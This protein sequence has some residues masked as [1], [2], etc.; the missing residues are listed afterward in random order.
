MLVS[1]NMPKKLAANLKCPPVKTA[2][3]TKV[4]QPAAP[5]IVNIIQNSIL[6]ICLRFI[7]YNPLF[8]PASL[9]AFLFLHLDNLFNSPIF[10]FKNSSN[11]LKYIGHFFN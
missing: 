4:T 3:I 11:H 1:I 8:E 7:Q 6:R 9:I 10:V 2:K 5:T